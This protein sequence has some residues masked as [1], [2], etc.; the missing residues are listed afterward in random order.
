MTQ[1]KEGLFGELTRVELG[2]AN[3]DESMR[4]ALLFFRENVMLKFL[5]DAVIICDATIFFIITAI[6]LNIN[7]DFPWNHLLTVLL[8]DE[9]LSLR[10]LLH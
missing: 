1:A 4:V 10:C 7:R 3:F 6:N 8:E 9:S 2:L 5:F